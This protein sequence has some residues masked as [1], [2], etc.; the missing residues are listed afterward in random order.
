MYRLKFKVILS[1]KF[2]IGNDFVVQIFRESRKNLPISPFFNLSG[3]KNI[4]ATIRIGR[5]IRCLL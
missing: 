5:E 3:N 4:G 1:F 2:I